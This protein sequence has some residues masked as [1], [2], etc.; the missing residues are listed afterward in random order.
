MIILRCIAGRIVLTLQ[1]QASRVQGELTLAQARRL[2]GEL[3]DLITTLELGE[4][5]SES[6]D[7]LIEQIGRVPQL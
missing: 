1:G 7:A 3:G 6:L 4:E 2:Q 5:Q